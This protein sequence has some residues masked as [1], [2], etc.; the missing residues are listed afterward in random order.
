MN[1]K[2][3]II[4][5]ALVLKLALVCVALNAWAAEPGAKAD[6]E[7]FNQAPLAKLITGNIG[8][9]LVLKSELGIT[10]AQKKSIIGIVKSHRDKIRPVVKT[11]IEKRRALRDA[12]LKKPGDETAIRGAGVEMGKAIGDAAVL[13]SKIVAQ[14]KPEL[15]SQQ[16]KRIEKFRMDTQKATTEWLSDMGK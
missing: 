16:I 7:T 3:I 14:V 2:T 9:F 1:K 8:R 5:S 12:V 11:I 10:A 15:T 4:A 6:I 13:A